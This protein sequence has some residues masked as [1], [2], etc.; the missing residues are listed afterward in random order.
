[1]AVYV[2]ATSLASFI[3]CEQMAYFRLFAKG[4][5][6]PPN[7]EQKL[8]IITHKILQKS[9]NDKDN[10]IKLIASMSKK[11][12]LDAVGVQS[13][14]H[15][16][17][18]YFERFYIL[19]KETDESEK[20]FKVKLEKDI[21][22]VGVFDRVGRIVIDWKTNASPAKRV[23]NDIQFILYDLAYRKLYNKEPY[24][25]YMAALKDGSLVKYNQNSLYI[26]ALMEEV[27]PKFVDVVKSR[28]FY[29]NG[30]FNG[31]C[32]RCNFKEPCLGVQNVVVHPTT[33]EE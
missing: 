7:R 25:V 3:K 24:G 30:I 1:M 26:N 12:E 16:I 11:E 10:A 4:E 28:S 8:G 29:R 14:H 5:P 6:P 31:S 21:Y 33:F 18:T 17:N 19:T 20:R 23:D 9:W 27:I 22:L 32:Y 13:L 2:S 15:F